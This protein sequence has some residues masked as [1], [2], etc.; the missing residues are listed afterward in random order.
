MTRS[1]TFTVLTVASSGN[2]LLCETRRIMPKRSP[3]FKWSP[4]FRPGHYPPRDRAGK[5]TDNQREVRRFKSPRYC[6]ILG[7]AFGI[8]R[9]ERKTLVT[10]PR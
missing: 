5:L 10:L 7:G 1:P 2:I 8:A 9:I 4:Y 3:F 6:L